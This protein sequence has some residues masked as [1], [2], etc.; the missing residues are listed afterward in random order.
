MRC[1]RKRSV[2]R[3]F[4][5]C[6]ARRVP[7]LL[8]V[9]L[10]A[11]VAAGQTLPVV[12]QPLVTTGGAGLEYLEARSPSAL[13]VPPTIATG[14]L[15]AAPGLRSPL[16]VSRELGPFVQRMWEAS[17]TFRRQCARLGEALVTIVVG[18]DSRMDRDKMNAVTSIDMRNG[19]VRAATTHLRVLEPEYLAHEIEHVLEQVDGVDIRRSARSGLDGVREIHSGMFETA[20]AIAIGRVVAREIARRDG[21]R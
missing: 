12:G 18:L 2:V 15:P 3:R 16:A 5:V 10:A 8:A 4:A 6:L 19:L 17:P 1:E 20:R 11:A 9:W 7:A 21:D 14:C 13:A